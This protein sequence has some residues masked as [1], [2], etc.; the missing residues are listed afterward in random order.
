MCPLASAAAGMHGM[1]R[2]N[3][4]LHYCVEQPVR[5]AGSSLAFETSNMHSKQFDLAKLLF[6][7]KPMKALLRRTG[8]RTACVT[9]HLHA[10]SSFGNAHGCLSPG[11][12]ASQWEVWEL[13]P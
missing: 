13:R 12:H 4:E 5:S 6:D 1:Y 8:A 2:I 3:P 11:E 7:Y 10:C 9:V